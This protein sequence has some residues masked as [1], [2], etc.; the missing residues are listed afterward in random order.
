MVG[1]RHVEVGEWRANNHF[2][3][4]ANSVAMEQRAVE[5]QPLVFTDKVV[6]HFVDSHG[7]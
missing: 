6:S 5:N 4:D 1:N 7:P 3:F 2:E